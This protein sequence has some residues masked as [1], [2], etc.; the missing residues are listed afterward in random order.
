MLKPFVLYAYDGCYNLLTVIYTKIKFVIFLMCLFVVLYFMWSFFFFV[1]LWYCNKVYIHTVDSAIK[2][3]KLSN[4]F[5]TTSVFKSF[6]QH[7]V[8]VSSTT[9]KSTAKLKLGLL[10]RLGRGFAEFW[11]NRPV[12]QYF[13]QK[14]DNSTMSFFF[15]WQIKQIWRRSRIW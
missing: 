8:F 15:F 6:C 14:F 12:L 1:E 3:G 10:V 11:L 5:F 2:S 13:R 7:T 4:S 9:T